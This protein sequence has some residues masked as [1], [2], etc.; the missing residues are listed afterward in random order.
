[1]LS[2]LNCSTNTNNTHSSLLAGTP[3]GL[4]LFRPLAVSPPRR[5]AT[6]L[7]RPLARSPVGYRCLFDVDCCSD[8]FDYRVMYKRA[9]KL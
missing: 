5:F 6:W 9:E 1:M 8:C 3:Q 4:W 2:T 7:F